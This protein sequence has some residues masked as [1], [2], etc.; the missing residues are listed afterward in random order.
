QWV[1]LAT[2]ADLASCQTRLAWAV[3]TQRERYRQPNGYSRL[4]AFPS[5]IDN[6]R[7]YLPSADAQSWCL[8]RVVT[9]LTE[10]CFERKVEKNGCVTLFANRYSVG[11]QYAR[12]TLAI[13]LDPAT[14]EWLF[15]DPGQQLVARHPA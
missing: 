11:R 6:P 1:E 10:F 3:R 2:C 14:R 12:Q 8:D 15:T 4:Q 5:L 7:R 9:Y 13:R